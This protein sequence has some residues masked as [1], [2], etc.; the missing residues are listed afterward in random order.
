MRNGIRTTKS[1]MDDDSQ[2][3]NASRCNPVGAQMPQNLVDS[4]VNLLIICRMDI[5]P[6]FAIA[7][8]SRWS[9]CGVHPE[10]YFGA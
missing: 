2:N 1:Q 4:R 10:W 5:R 7:R 9:S 3:G 8:G 6:D